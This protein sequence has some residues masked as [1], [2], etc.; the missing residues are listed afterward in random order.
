MSGWPSLNDRNKIA[1]DE[2]RYDDIKCAEFELL[3]IYATGNI[4]Q[5]YGNVRLAPGRKNQSVKLG[6]IHMVVIGASHE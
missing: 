2:G 4:H 1:G 3:A 5:S 6:M